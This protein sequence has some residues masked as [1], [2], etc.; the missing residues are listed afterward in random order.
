MENEKITW[1]ANYKTRDKFVFGGLV[2]VYC[3]TNVLWEL[4]S[5]PGHLLKVHPPC[6]QHETEEWKGVGSKDVVSYKDGAKRMRTVIKWEPEQ[7][8]QLHVTN[9]TSNEESLVSYNIKKLPEK[10]QCEISV[11]LE[12]TSYKKIP[13]LFW[14]F[15]ART[16]LLPQY[17][18]YLVGLLLGFAEFIP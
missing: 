8:L 16:I 15:Y 14:K 11:I 12:T 10:D 5:S 2:K 9:P 6:T 7:L 18:K 4:L 3:Q 13:R 1:I 17:K